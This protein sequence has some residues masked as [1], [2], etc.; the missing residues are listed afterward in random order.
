LI[1]MKLPILNEKNTKIGEQELPAQFSEPVRPDLIAR[2]V[3]ALQSLARQAYGA[4]P[5]SGLRHSSTISKERRHYRG[6][7]GHG[8][9][10]VNRK[11]MSRK[12]TRFNWVGA[13]SPQTRG[14]HPAHPPKAAKIWAQKINV[15]ENRKAIRSA[16]AATV[17]HELVEKRG[18]KLPST[19]PFVL[20]TGVEQLSTAKEVKALL[21]ALGFE[22][23]MDRASVKKVRSG[24]GKARGRKYKTKTSLLMVVSEECPLIKAAKNFPGVDVV[25]AR[26][27]NA[28]VLAPGACPGRVTLWTKKSIEA[29]EKNKLFL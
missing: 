18:H 17:K 14:G 8:I 7:Y 13:F 9:S 28:E 12:G 20:D 25:S 22:K 19:Y 6:C 10:R 2:A 29:L 11:I 3:H 16:M 27:L 4:S 15:K 21:L 23:E 1:K 5:D 24:V 26:A